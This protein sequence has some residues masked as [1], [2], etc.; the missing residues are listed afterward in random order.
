MKKSIVD[1]ILDGQKKEAVLETASN[2]KVVT[3]EVFF[4]SYCSREVFSTLLNSLTKKD[5][6][7]LDFLFNLMKDEKKFNVSPFETLDK[8]N[9][10]YVW[11]EVNNKNTSSGLKVRTTDNM[12]NLINLYGMGFISF[13]CNLEDI[14]SNLS[15]G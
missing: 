5:L 8:D 14:Y 2:V 13:K 4:S 10:P 12:W 9:N 6:M 3:P 7:S 1:L 15:K 11:V